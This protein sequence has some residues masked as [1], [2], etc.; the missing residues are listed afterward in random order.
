VGRGDAA[1]LPVMAFTNE[2]GAQ[3]HGHK[4][5]QARVDP[6]VAT[7]FLNGVA[8]TAGRSFTFI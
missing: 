7:L 2:I 1:F 6:K 3:T 4:V 8:A 5:Q